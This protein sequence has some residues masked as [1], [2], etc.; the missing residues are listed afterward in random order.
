MEKFR[1]H[2]MLPHEILERRASCPVGFVGLGTLEWHA[3]HAAVG[4]D[5]L[6]A[7]GLCE[8]AAQAIG[9]FAFPTVWYGEP[10]SA[11]HMDADQPETSSIRAALRL[12]PRPPVPRAVVEQE[13]QAFQSLIQRVALQLYELEM[14]VV[15]FLCGHFP[16]L[17]WARRSAE[18]LNMDRSHARTLVGTE[19]EFAQRAPHDPLVVPASDHAAVWETSYLWYLRADCVDMSVYTDAPDM[20]LLGVAGDDPRLAASPRLGRR[21]SELAVAGMV[22]SVRDELR[23]LASP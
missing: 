21:A 23:A 11:E 19:T 22:A 4:L 10:R 15:C 6:K 12:A 8:L 20:P 13:V 9:G 1:Y 2:E 14:K 18:S 7:E 17:A 3:H 5:G 16:L